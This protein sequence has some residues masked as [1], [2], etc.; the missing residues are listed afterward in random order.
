[1]HIEQ[2]AAMALPQWQHTLLNLPH[3]TIPQLSAEHL[4]LDVRHDQPGHL[5]HKVE[6]NTDEMLV[7]S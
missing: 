1:M 4:M 7:R 6:R 2:L 3:L 5:R